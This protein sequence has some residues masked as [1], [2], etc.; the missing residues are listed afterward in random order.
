MDCLDGF[1]FLEGFENVAKNLSISE[2]SINGGDLGW[3]KEDIISE[4][5]KSTIINTPVGYLSE[6][7]ILSEAILLFKVRD[8]RKVETNISLEDM[9]NQLINTEKTKILNMHSLSHYDKVRRT[10]TVK[11]YK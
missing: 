2:S 5:I 7:I 3:L 10:I 11:F 4:K 6:P 8:K 9:K 1:F